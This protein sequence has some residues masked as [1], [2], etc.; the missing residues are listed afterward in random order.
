MRYLRALAALGLLAALAACAQP[1]APPQL[2]A[3]GQPVQRVYR[4]SAAD[5]QR[6]PFRALDSVNT[7]RSG[8]GLAP[9]ELNSA[10]N[11]AAATH[12]RDMSSQG[13]PWHFG[14]DGSSPVERVS[15]AGYAG[16]MRG[17]LVSE[18]FESE[19][20]TLRA[21]MQERDT[22]SLLLD[23]EARDM[24]FAFHQEANGKLWWTLVT[25]VPSQRGPVPSGPGRIAGQGVM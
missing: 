17:E 6:I 2:G 14:S 22:R 9:L 16:A 20:E 21:W 7:L 3:D 8:R 24:G 12:A 15:R 5:E 4:I 25:G 10:L 13:R 19:L 11:A 1:P 23:P 18:T